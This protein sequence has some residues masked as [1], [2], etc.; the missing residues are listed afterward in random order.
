MRLAEGGGE[1]GSQWLEIDT[2]VDIKAEANSII[3]SF[4][5][6]CL[7]PSVSLDGISPAT[8]LRLLPRT[9]SPRFTAPSHGRLEETPPTNTTQVETL[10]RR[11]RT[12]QAL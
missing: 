8:Q 6:S 7:A 2:S 1:T 3:R 4:S 10:A 12:H 9:Q 5:Q 11:G